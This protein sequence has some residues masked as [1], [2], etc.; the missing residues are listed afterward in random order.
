M[1]AP[2]EI[3]VL[4]GNFG[5]IGL[6]HYLFKITI[7]SLQ[8]LDPTKTFH[9]TLVTPNTDLFFKIGSP[10]ALINDKLI[11]ESKIL[12]P[13]S[14]GFSKYKPE[15]FTLAQ[16]LATSHDA[17]K[18]TVT[19][20]PVGSETTKELLY[21]SLFIATGTTSSSPLWTFH[22]DPAL[23]SAAFKSLHASLPAAKTVLIAGGGAVGIET[24]GEIATFFPS[25]K[26][27]LLSGAA[28]LLP[29]QSPVL[30]P[31]AQAYLETHAK[32]EVIHNLRV[33][34]SDI[35]ETGTTMTLSDGSTK[36]TDL[37]I[38]AT[39]GK[40][41]TEFLK[42]DWLDGTKRVLTRDAYFRVK[43]NGSDDVEGVYVLGDVVAGSANSAMA[44]DGQTPTVASAFAVDFARK[45]IGVEAGEKKNPGLLGGLVGLVFGKKDA[46][47]SLVEF[48]PMKDTIVVPIGPHGG[49]GL[50]MGWRFP[51]FFISKVKGKSFLLELV[52]PL[53]TGD[54]WKA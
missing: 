28:Q 20:T 23:T 10:R 25:I 33:Y 37:Y 48:K 54:K 36:T 50:V 2:H 9:I 15:Q 38:D 24:A 34:G 17:S 30:G 49:V 44:L 43:G 41:N 3:L 27:T 31:R 13:L 16:A 32:V 18:R 5:G 8:K 51:S 52:D 1:S 53:L 29:N 46:A 22:P 14:E 21:N 26:V 47:P 19:I 42:A 7:P 39:G 40:A 4:G 11:P 45:V 6:V 12:R 35:S